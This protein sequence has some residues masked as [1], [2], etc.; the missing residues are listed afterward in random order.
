MTVTPFKTVEE[1]QAVIDRGGLDERQ[2]LDQWECLYLDPAKIAALLATVQER[3]QHELSVLL[4]AI[5][6]YPGCDVVKCSACHG[7][8]SI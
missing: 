5:P 1:I 7:P 4:H 6:A 3:A 2:S 8:T